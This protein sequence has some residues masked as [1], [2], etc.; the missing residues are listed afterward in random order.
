MDGNTWGLIAVAVLNAG[1]ALLAWQ[2]KRVSTDNS[3]AV[4]KVEEKVDGLHE[5]VNGRLSQLIAANAATSTAEV[6][7]AHGE[8][9]EVGRK[10]ATEDRRGEEDRAKVP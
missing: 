2:S 3:R 8:G 7:A 4:A 10:L 5:S 6:A 1:T 9:I